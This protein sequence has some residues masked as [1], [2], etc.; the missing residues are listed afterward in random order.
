VKE[1]NFNI[2]ICKNGKA[3][4]NID[5]YR[6]S[7]GKIT[8]L[9]GESGIG[10]TLANKA[11]FGLLDDSL[12][13]IKINGLNYSAFKNHEICKSFR[14]N[15]FFVFQEP[16]SHLNPLIKISEQL[17]EGDISEKKFDLKVLENLWHKSSDKFYDD[18][19]DIYPK[20]YRPSGGEKQRVL[21]AMAF[22]KMM[23]SESFDDRNLFVFDEPT[24]NLDNYFRDVFLDKLI[25]EYKKSRFTVVFITHDYSIIAYM[26]KKY[27][28]ILGSVSYKELYRKGDASFL[29]E[30]NPDE[31]LSFNFGK[32]AGKQK[33]NGELVLAVK[34]G[35]KVFGRE[36][37]FSKDEHTNYRA[38][39]KVH[40]G[41]ITYL[42]APSGEGKTTILKIIMGLVK[43]EE[44]A[45]KFGDT[46]VEQTTSKN[47]WR[48]NIWGKYAGLVFQHAD[49]ALNLQSKVKEVFRALPLKDELTDEE[50]IRYLGGVFEE[51]VT[52][53]FLN[54][55]IGQLS[56]GQK[57]KINLMRT[58]LLDTELILLDEPTSG[59][60]FNSIK[61]FLVLLGKK[62]K[63]GKAILLVSHNE[64]IFDPLVTEENTYYLKTAE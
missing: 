11:I 16:S 52:P 49:E 13:D 10:K 61:K 3:I 15:G 7:E 5:K 19:I 47:Y 2:D 53:A 34:S 9:F 1:Y 38:S 12:L 39:L 35:I 18:V 29:R 59:M 44:A 23:L 31:F 36:L 63:E 45:L 55:K 46:I 22:K 56:G 25:T 62:I 33:Q 48:E 21:A 24:G 41:A 14:K 27:R 37:I 60:D 64:D 42:K 51:D 43:P 8:F 54:K 28:D 57:Q 32:F 6:F 40:K 20:P 58:F 30:F 26:Q 17:A 4:V 50:L